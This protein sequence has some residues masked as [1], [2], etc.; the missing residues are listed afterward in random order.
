M[1]IGMFDVFRNALEAVQT[2]CAAESFDGILQ[3]KKR[4]CG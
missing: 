1:K 3:K 2:L 4:D